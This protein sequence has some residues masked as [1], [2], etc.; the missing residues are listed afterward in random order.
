MSLRVKLAMTSDALVMT[1]DLPMR[2]PLFSND[3]EQSEKARHHED[4]PDILA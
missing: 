4:L 2:Q 3:R 1:Y